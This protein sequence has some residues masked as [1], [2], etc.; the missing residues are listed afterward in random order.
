MKIDS[1]ES[2]PTRLGSDY[3]VWRVTFTDSMGTH[4]K[5]FGHGA[6]RKI[7]SKPGDFGNFRRD[8]F[9]FVVEAE[10]DSAYRK[11]GATFAQ[12]CEKRGSDLLLSMFLQVA[13]LLP[14]M[15]AKWYL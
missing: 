1:V 9:K 8:L 11:H 10:R 6:A 12:H 4:T 13:D 15:P 3:D 7:C 2:M 5:L 14:G